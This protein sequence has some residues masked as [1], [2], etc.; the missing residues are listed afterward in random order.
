MAVAMCVA[1]VANTLRVVPAE[2][3]ISLIAARHFERSM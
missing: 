3:A 2:F 1:L